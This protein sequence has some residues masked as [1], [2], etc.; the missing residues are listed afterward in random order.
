VEDYVVKPHSFDEFTA[1]IRTVLEYA[2][3]PA[4][5]QET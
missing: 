2:L 3:P 5:G 4:Q 1:V